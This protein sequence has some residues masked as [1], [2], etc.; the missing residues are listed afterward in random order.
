MS[1]DRTVGNTCDVC[2]I[3]FEIF[4]IRPSLKNSLFAAADPH[5]LEWVA[6]FFF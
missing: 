6:F 2:K 5:F 4:H 3:V 1:I